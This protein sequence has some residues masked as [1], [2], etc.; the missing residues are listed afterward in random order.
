MSNKL[1]NTKILIIGASG[2]IGSN[3]V[4]QILKEPVREVVLY[5]NFTRGKI[6]NIEE[7]LKDPRCNIFPYGGD[8]R[9]IDVLDKAMEGVDYVFL[10][11]NVAFAL[12]RF[13]KNSF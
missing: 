2:F 1:E 3:L 4:K 11:C 13:S 10:C 8:I 7:F 12:Q 5:D 9:D 6:E